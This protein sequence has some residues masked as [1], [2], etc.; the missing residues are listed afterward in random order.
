MSIALAEFE[1]RALVACGDRSGR[2]RV[3]DAGSGAV[4]WTSEAHEVRFG[5]ILGVRRG[6]DSGSLGETMVCVYGGHK[7]FQCQRL[8]ED[9]IVSHARAVSGLDIL[10]VDGE[11]YVVSAG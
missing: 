10:I 1:E 11:D 6:S 9:V 2:I 3:S 4:I 8:E 5:L 7:R